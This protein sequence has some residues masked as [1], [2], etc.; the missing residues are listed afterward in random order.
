MEL[1]RWAWHW[2][3]EWKARQC[4]QVEALESIATELKRLRELQEHRLGV[5]VLRKDG[6]VE[7]EEKGPES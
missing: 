7:T 1:P 5:D 6:D 4:R 2:L 3:E